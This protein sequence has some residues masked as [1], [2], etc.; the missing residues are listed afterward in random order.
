VDSAY[1]RGKAVSMAEHLEID[2]VIDPAESR[3]RVAAMLASM[4]PS[5]VPHEKRR[6]FVDTW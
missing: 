6:S 3:A 5:P 4:P 2:D 1:E